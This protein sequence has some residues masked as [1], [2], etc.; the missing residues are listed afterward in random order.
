MKRTLP[1]V[2]GVLVLVAVAFG[3]AQ[4][5]SVRAGLVERQALAAWKV[6]T[7]IVPIPDLKL[8]RTQ[9]Y[10]VS[11]K[12]GPAN[13]PLS[14]MLGA[15]GQ[16]AFVHYA[17]I[18]YNGA[19]NREAGVAHGYLTSLVAQDCIGLD[20][21]T[22]NKIKG[23][24][25]TV[26][27]QLKSERVSRTLRVGPVMAEASAAFANNQLSVVMILERADAPGQTW[28]RYCGFEK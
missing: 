5:R 11:L 8:E 16:N 18:I 15:N 13:T 19:A 17:A 1:L 20:S 2:F 9:M 22:M 10:A 7:P 23:L 27:S 24:M 26:I 14:L 21:A 3:Q 25:N 4:E 12:L 6:Q 28:G